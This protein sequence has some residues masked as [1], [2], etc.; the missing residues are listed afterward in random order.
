MF[1]KMLFTAAAFVVGTAV[2]AYA[3]PKEDMQA[4]IK[5]LADQPNYSWH[6]TTDFGQGSSVSDGKTEKGGLTYTK[7]TFGDNETEM[8]RQGDK[9]VINRGGEGWMTPEEMQQN[10]GGGGGRGRGF[11]GRGGGAPMVQAEQAISN[12]PD[13]AFSKNGDVYT[14]TATGAEAQSLN[15]FGGRGG[16]RGGGAGGG[17]QGPQN[18]KATYKVTVKDGMPS[19]I[20]THYSATVNFGGNEQELNITTTTEIKNVGSTKIDVPAQAKA[21]LQG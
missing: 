19:K 2:V 9:I 15:P 18:A 17:G 10:A 21:K 14:V 6:S 7:S 4:G 5:K 3:G 13:S 16:R 1:R 12:L 11:F 20:E 8:I